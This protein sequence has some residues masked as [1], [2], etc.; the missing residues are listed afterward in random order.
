MQ[1]QN[2]GRIGRPFVNEM[3]GRLSLGGCSID[4]HISWPSVEHLA[5]VLVYLV[6]S[7]KEVKTMFLSPVPETTLFQAYGFIQ[8]ILAALAVAC[9]YAAKKLG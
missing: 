1:Q 2:G 9:F 8:G 4:G 7:G 3:S 6:Y 5:P